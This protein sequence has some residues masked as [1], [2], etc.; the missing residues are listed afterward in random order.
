MS[1]CSSNIF[2]KRDRSYGMQRIFSICREKEYKNETMFL[3][4]NI[5]DRYLMH[6]GHWNLP[7]GNVVCLFTISILIAAKIEQPI[8]PSYNRMIRMLEERE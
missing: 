3:A 1:S 4:A 6:L 5:F 7:V 8:M 2:Q